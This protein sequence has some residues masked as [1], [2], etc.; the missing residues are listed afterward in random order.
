MPLVYAS[1]HMLQGKLEPLTRET[2]VNPGKDLRKSVSRISSKI[3]RVSKKEGV[4]EPRLEP[5][6]HPSEKSV[7]AR[8]PLLLEDS[9]C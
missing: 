7:F 2:L 9:G 5:P 6:E 1:A 8:D 4:S 3:Q